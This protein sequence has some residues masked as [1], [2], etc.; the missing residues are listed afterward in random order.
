[1]INLVKS[2]YRQISPF[3]YINNT[4]KTE[5]WINV[6]QNLLVLDVDDGLSIKEAKQK[7][8]EY[9]SLIYTTKSHQQD[10][11]GV[12]CDRFRVIIPSIN[13][14]TDETYFEYM[15][16]LEMLFPFIDKQVNNKTGAFLGNFNCEH[17]Y[18]EGKWFD[19]NIIKP[20]KTKKPEPMQN[21]N[22]AMPKTNSYANNEEIDTQQLKSRL[23]REMVA[24][25]VSSCGYDV[26]RKFMFK[27]RQ[28]EKTPS[29]S[30]SP[31]LLIKDFGSE[32]STDCIGF[33]MQTKNIDF[34]ESVNYIKK[35]I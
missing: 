31:D 2:D 17:F 9:K 16:N 25:I 5:N 15:R 14:P 22:R 29:A 12:T 35:Y 3:E 19:F 27:Y 13:I 26:N 30:I 10:K 7:F 8:K 20:V 1:L 28:N 32:L 23:T 11:K 6:K 4:K 24:D 21:N 18:N 34:I 33:V